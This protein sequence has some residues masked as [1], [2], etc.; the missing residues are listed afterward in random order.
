[1]YN[2]TTGKSETKNFDEN[3]FINNLF[4]FN[5][6]NNSGVLSINQKISKLLYR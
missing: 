5:E 2:T 3:G 4:K 1:M 6:K